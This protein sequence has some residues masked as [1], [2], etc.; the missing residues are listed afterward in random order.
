MLAT[1]HTG[2]VAGIRGQII[3]V[4]VDSAPGFPGL[5]MVG[6]PDSAVR[7]SESRIKA[8]LRNSSFDFSWDRRITVNL[9]P[10]HLRKSGSAFDL[11]IAVALLAAAGEPVPELTDCVFLGELAL[12]GSLRPVPGV[13]PILIEARSR[14]FRRAIVPSNNWRE[15]VLVKGLEVRGAGS[16]LAAIRPNEAGA[17][18]PES[19]CSGDSRPA[20]LDLD[21]VAGQPL[22]RRA[23]EIAAAG[24]HNLLMIGPPGS[25]KTMLARRLPGILPPPSDQESLEMTAIQSAAGSCPEGLVR[26]RPFRAPHHTASSAALVGGGAVPRPGEISLAHGGVL[27]LDELPE[28]PRATLE[29]LRQPLEEGRLIVSRARATF[30]F[31]SRFQ[32]VAAMNPCPCGYLGDSVLPCRCTPGAIARYQARVSGPLLDRIDLVVEVPRPEIKIDPSRDLGRGSGGEPSGPVRARV[33]AAIRFAEERRPGRA[34]GHTPLGLEADAAATLEMVARVQGLSLRGVHRTARV[35]RT[36]ADLAHSETVSKSAV[37]EALLFR[38]GA[39]L[40]SLK[41]A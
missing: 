27:F 6:L 3:R 5:F 8:S 40:T 17:A 28:F 9:A 37:L 22:A 13:L 18:P 36:I 20:H 15:A 35:A 41:V 1:T 19:A 23:L 24:R 38:A 4:E 14:G 21:D 16:L 25:G 34:G 39:A 10:A 12:D 11:A 29:G 30:E 31:P 26:V 32:F 33:A 2:A 7:E